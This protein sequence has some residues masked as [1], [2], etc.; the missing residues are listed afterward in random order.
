[1]LSD[2]VTDSG[3]KF[4]P[5]TKLMPKAVS[6]QCLCKGVPAHQSCPECW[7]LPFFAHHW[8]RALPKPC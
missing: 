4:K 6:I 5:K 1:M 3:H 2:P 7:T 8:P